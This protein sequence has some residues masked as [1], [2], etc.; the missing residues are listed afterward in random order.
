VSEDTDFESFIDIDSSG[1][2]NIGDAFVG[3][4]RFDS[5]NGINAGIAGET[6]TAVLFAQIATL[7][8]FAGGA[9]VTF[10]AL[11]A[12]NYTFLDGLFGLP[13][14]ADAASAV[15]VYQDLGGDPFI[16]DPPA[17][18]PSGIASA[19][20]GEKILEFGF[21][22]GAEAEAELSFSGVTI[23]D[24]DFTF[25]LN[26]TAQMNSGAGLTFLKTSGADT[27]AP[28]FGAV[29]GTLLP[30]SDLVGIGDRDILP[31][32]AFDFSTDTIL[33]TRIVPEPASLSLMALGM[34]AVMGGA[35]VRRRKQAA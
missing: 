31:S 28:I 18:I 2:I 19:S 29:S 5:I 26:L 3:I 8:P 13:T 21:V 14:R 4:L 16:E 9:D 1:S 17:S 34:A 22:D 27:P 15:L 24:I 32:G 10:E 35:G 20:D 12:A 25:A 7:D 11:S 33:F 30:A 23:S 6:L